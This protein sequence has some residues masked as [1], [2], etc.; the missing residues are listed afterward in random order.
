[1]IIYSVTCSIEPSIEE[2]WLKWMKEVH[3]PEVMQTNLFLNHTFCEVLTEATGN[4]NRTFNIQ[5]EL[6]N[7][8]LLHLYNT[9]FAPGLKQK[10]IEKYGEKCLAFRSILRKL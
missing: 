4:D 6:E 8:G 9:K 3:I 2:E 1:M 5:Y 10:T 7:M